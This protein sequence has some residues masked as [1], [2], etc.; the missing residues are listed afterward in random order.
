MD[1]RREH[2]RRSITAA[3]SI[4]Q[5]VES[6]CVR[7]A[8]R[9]GL[10][11]I[12]LVHRVD[13]TDASRL[14][15]ERLDRQRPD[16]GFP[17]AVVDGTLTKRAVQFQYDDESDGVNHTTGTSIPFYP[18][19]DEAITQAHWIEGGDPGTLTSGAAKTVIC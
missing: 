10:S 11:R 2:E 3:V 1:T 12:Y 9:S 5:L 6:G 7:G 16:Y 13:A 8:G 4:E 19:P 18:I 15:R 14:R 17:Y